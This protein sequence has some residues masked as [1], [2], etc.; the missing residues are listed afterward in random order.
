MKH[1]DTKEPLIAMAFMST[2]NVALERNVPQKGLEGVL[3]LEKFALI[4]G[5]S[6]DSERKYQLTDKNACLVYVPK[7]GTIGIHSI[8]IR[9]RK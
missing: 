7:N 5:N 4:K 3:G 1:L 2:T 9:V 8:T 6:T